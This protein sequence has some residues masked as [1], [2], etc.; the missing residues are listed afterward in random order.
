MVRPLMHRVFSSLATGLVLL[1]LAGRGSHFDLALSLVPA[2]CHFCAT[3]RLC[4]AYLARS[5]FLDSTRR[6]GS[7]HFGLASNLGAA[8]SRYFLFA[9]QW[10][11][12][13]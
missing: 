9:R 6:V 8:L 3:G 10:S 13:G 4:L 5:A 1:F 12:D 7:G 11:S 2:F